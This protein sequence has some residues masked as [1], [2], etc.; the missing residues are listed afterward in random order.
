M[1]KVTNEEQLKKA[2]MMQH[3]RNYAAGSKRRELEND[4]FQER[5]EALPSELGA[6]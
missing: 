4:A 2:K 6:R 5:D 3:D 1:A